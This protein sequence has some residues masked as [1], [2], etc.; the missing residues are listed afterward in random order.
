[1]V[2][3]SYLMLSDCIEVC[4]MFISF[5]CAGVVVPTAVERKEQLQFPVMGEVW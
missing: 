5:T 1:M 2:S 4:I 3:K